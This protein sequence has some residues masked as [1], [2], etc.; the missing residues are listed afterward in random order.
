M[1]TRIALMGAGGKMG[2]RITDN[3]KDLPHYH[4][5]Y[6]E[7]SEQGKANLAQRGVSVTPQD[8]ALAN[9]DAII[10]AVPDALIGRITHSIIP[11]LKPG[12]MVIGLDPAA[13]Y[14]EVMPIRE[15][16]TYFVTH[17]CHPPLF[18]DEVTE[19]ARTDWFGGVK[20]K[21]HIVCALHHGPEED[22]A[23]G[24]AI[25][26]DI[27]KPV[28]KSFRITVEQMAILEPALAETFTATVITAV[29]QA[30]DKAV[31][32]GVPPEAAWEFLSG[33]ARIEFA[34]IFG[35]SGF[36]FSDGAKLAIANAYD[37]IFK[38]DWMEQIMNLDALKKSVEDIT[39]KVAK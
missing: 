4:V 19:E 15:D 22:Y 12:T 29:K 20:A 14:A 6:V 38:P 30:Y 26:L 7:V 23:K 2:C 28:M 24:E 21:H 10:L 13:A 35:I 32:M 11:Q 18:N 39:H 33:H 1:T 17:P 9:A 16:L 25:A 36:P 27:Y 3:I 37:K 31:E 8:E 34:I 5:Y